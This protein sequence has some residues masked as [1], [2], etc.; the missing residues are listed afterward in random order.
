MIS[1]VSTVQLPIYNQYNDTAQQARWLWGGQTDSCVNIVILTNAI[2]LFYGWLNRF[3]VSLGVGCWGRC[4]VLF[5]FIKTGKSF[6]FCTK[7]VYK[8]SG[9]DKFLKGPSL[10]FWIMI[11]RSFNCCEMT[12]KPLPPTHSCKQ[13][14][15]R[16]EINFRKLK[17]K[18]IICTGTV[19]S[20]PLPTVIIK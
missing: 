9:Y 20:A 18:L 14:S 7:I 13:P 5:W 12:G 17:L 4:F 3:T 1:C 11:C 6:H 16:E 10:V 2:M 19:R 15:E 8:T